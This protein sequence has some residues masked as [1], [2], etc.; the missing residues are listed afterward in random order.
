MG[1]R[2]GQPTSAEQNSPHH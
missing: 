1:I 2:G